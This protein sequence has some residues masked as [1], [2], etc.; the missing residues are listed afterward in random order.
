MNHYFS[1]Q[2]DPS[3]LQRNVAMYFGKLL[4]VLAA[5]LV[6]SENAVAQI[7][8]DKNLLNRDDAWFRSNEAKAIADSVIQYQS[9][10]GGWPKSTELSNPP[11]TPDDIP[12]PGGGRANSFDND[13]TTVPMHFLA[14]MTHLTGS[15]KY[16]D[17]FLKGV[18]YILA[19][20]YPNG[21]WPQFWPLRKG[22]YSHITYNDGAMIRVMEVVREIAGGEAPY[23]FVDAER[24]DKAAKAMALGIDCLLKTQ[25]RQ[26]GKPTAWCAQHDANTLEP[27]WAR[28]YEPP[29]LSGSESVGIVRFLMKIEE[30]S[31]EIIASVEGAVQWLRK[32]QIKDWRSDEVTNA[33]G[34]RERLLIADPKAPPLWARFYELKTHRPLY[35]DRDSEFRYDYN[36]ISYERRSGYTYHGTWAQ[37]V[38]EKDYPRWCEQNKGSAP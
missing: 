11:R 15:D 27:A 21:G 19:A 20:Q 17:A 38:L 12:P 22:Y 29:S 28:A 9:P 1:Q 4:A 23:E 2:I 32:V 5:A 18:D 37:S 8:F 35:L 34:R 16:R 24:R 13:A 33:D 36:T 26:E 3:L 31:A 10:Q 25:I 30:P 7:R 6:V 14:R